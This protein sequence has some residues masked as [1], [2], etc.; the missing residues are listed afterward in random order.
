MVFLFF[1]W[2]PLTFQLPSYTKQKGVDI[3]TKHLN[4]IQQKM[5]QLKTRLKKLPRGTLICARNG[6]DGRYIKWYTNTGNGYQYLP[7]R[8]RALA[9]DLA[10]RK[11]L[12]LQL[13]KLAQEY[14]LL[15]SYISF[16]KKNPYSEKIARLLSEDS[17]FCELLSDSFPDSE[18]FS[19]YAKIWVAEPYVKNTSHPENLLH[20]SL[21][22]E[23]LRSKSEVIIANALYMNHIPYRYE[24]EL[25]LGEITL[26]P[27]F[28]I[29]H[30]VT[31]EVFYWEHFGMMHSASYRE[32]AFQKIKLYG[33]HQIYPTEHL[34]TTYESDSLPLDSEK[35]Q[36]IIEQYFL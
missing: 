22:G 26:H 2:P 6:R 14:E 32:N 23:K 30:P 16:C 3:T 27:D 7:K 17:P 20:K 33:E 10:L 35:I 36:Q 19:D 25:I 28:T 31:S 24:C 1:Q 5:F 8:K 9:K 12:M 4:F 29:L 15:N 11:I 34:I 18:F 13:D 21:S